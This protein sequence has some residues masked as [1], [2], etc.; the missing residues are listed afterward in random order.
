[1]KIYCDY[2]GAQ[3]DPAIHKNCPNCGGSYSNDDELKAIQARANKLEDLDIEQ[4]RLEIERMRLENDKLKNYSDPRKTS[5]SP[6]CLIGLVF[7]ASLGV[8]FLI[9]LFFV[10][11]DTSLDS[12]SAQTAGTTA[13]SRISVSYSI[14]L[15]PID[16]P[17]IPEVPEITVVPEIPEMTGLPEI[18]EI[19][20]GKLTLPEQ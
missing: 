12:G 15:D 4:R 16:I 18:T 17:E 7:L 6:G 13:S 8:T 9:I 2:C 20:F 5:L 11:S 14:S 10:F 3:I 19:S 1:M